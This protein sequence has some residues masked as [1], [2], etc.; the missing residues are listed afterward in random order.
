MTKIYIADCHKMFAEGVASIVNKS[1]TAEVKGIFHD[2]VAC[3]AAIAKGEPDILIIDILQPVR[4]GIVFDEVAKNRKKNL[5]EREAKEQPSFYP[6][7][8]MDFCIK[9]K[10]YYPNIKIIVL[11]ECNHWVTIKY[12]KGL[13]I[14][15]Y[16][17]KSSPADEITKAIEN[18]KSDKF[19]L[20]EELLDMMRSIEKAS[21]FWLTVDQQILLRLIAEDLTNQEIAVIMPFSAETIKTKRRDLLDKFRDIKSQKKR[22]EILWY[23][24]ERSINREPTLMNKKNYGR[25]INSIKTAIQM[26]LIWED[27]FLIHKKNK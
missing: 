1:G 8:G 23:I 6:I 16:I 9:V 20:C 5:G 17:L 11:S 13:G 15:G 18:A 12:M 27:I 21:F 19:F 24:S 26:G 4:K 10:L 25:S 3:W 22:E 7:N 2:L 14:D